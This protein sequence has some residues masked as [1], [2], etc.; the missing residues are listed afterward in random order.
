MPSEYSPD[1]RIE[2]IA[3]G[4]KSGTWGTITNT[5][6]GTLIEDAI[7][8]LV[9]YTTGVDKYPLTALDGIEDQARCAALA[10]NTSYAGDFEVYVPPVSK[11]YV[12]KNTNGTYNATL[13]CSTVL[14]NTTAAGSGVTVPPG[15]TVLLRSDGTNV[16]E[17]LNHVVGNMSFGGDVSVSGDTAMSGALTLDGS[18]Y[19]GATQAATI[20]VASPTVI[21]VAASPATGSAI[22]FFTTGELPVEI[23]L[24]TTYYVDKIDATT[25]HISASPTLTPLISVAAAGSGAHSIGTMSLSITPAD[26]ANNTQIATTAFVQTKIN[27]IPVA[28]TNWDVSESAATQTATVTIASPAVVTVTTAPANNTAVSF[29]TTGALPTGITA[30]AA[31][32]VYNRSSTTYNLATSTGSAQFANITA[33]ATFTGS[34]SGTTLTVTA[35]TGGTISVGQEISGTGITAG[36][37]ITALGTGAG[38][39]GTYTVSVSQTVASTTITAIAAPA[40]VTVSSAPSNNDVVI[41]STTGTLPTGLTAGTQYYVVNRTST[42]FQVSA[43]SGGAAINTSGYTQSGTHTATSYTLVNTTG[44]QSGV[45]TETTSK[46]YFQYKAQNRMSVDLGGNAIFVGNVT[47]YGTP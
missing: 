11:L 14:G 3:N 30:D 36:T 20:S 13:Y 6:L 32:Y 28:L 18:A 5:N 41:F 19:M 44:S 1:L 34:I 24:G 40:I 25:F 27:A 29:S 23:T 33:G 4:E 12:F 9:T 43:T 35:V 21:T 7:S 47:A 31:Y 39:T 15:K 46:L 16:V 45:H 2:L 38:A 26:E 8:G 17:Q 10:I 37:T 22:T 42:T